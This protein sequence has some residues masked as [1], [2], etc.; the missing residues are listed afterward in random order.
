MEKV[1][2]RK[3]ILGELNVE[4]EFTFSAQVREKHEQTVDLGDDDAG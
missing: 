2:E 3:E 4:S 1:R